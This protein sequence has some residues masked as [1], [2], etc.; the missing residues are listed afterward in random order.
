MA[1]L[2][3]IFGLLVILR[4]VSIFLFYFKLEVETPVENNPPL[5]MLPPLD[6]K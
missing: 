3:N 4:V 2:E 1:D 6:T 5:P